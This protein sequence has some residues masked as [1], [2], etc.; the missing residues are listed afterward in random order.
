MVPVSLWAMALDRLRTPVKWMRAGALMFVYVP[1]HKE[2]WLCTC[3]CTF[4]IQIPVSEEQHGSDLQ[5]NTIL[6]EEGATDDITDMTTSCVS[7]EENANTESDSSTSEEC[8]SDDDDTGTYTSP[9]ELMTLCIY[10]Y[11]TCMCIIQYIRIVQ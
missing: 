10:M 8:T 2:P 3:T 4:Y 9:H 6:Q 7:E 5:A 1:T 11:I